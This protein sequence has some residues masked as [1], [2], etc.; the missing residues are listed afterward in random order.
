MIENCVAPLFVPA[1]R[2]ELLAKAAS[3]G[4]DAIIVDLEDAVAPA[5]KS[6][7][8]HALSG[9]LPMDVIVRIN[10]IRSPWFA[11]DAAA[12]ASPGIA[13][14]MLP[15]TETPDDIATLRAVLARPMPIIALVETPR[16]VANLDEIAPAAAR[17][18]FGTLDY[19][20]DLGCGVDSETL[21]FARSR[22]VLA[23]RLAGKP[24][25]I[26]GVT[27]DYRDITAC[28][29]DTRHAA[30]LGFGG[31]LC[32]HP[33]QVHTV[34]RGFTPSQEELRWAQRVL[35]TA[36]GAQGLDGMMVDAPVRVRAHRLLARISVTR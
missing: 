14:V 26:D 3:S 5:A 21:L 32:I 35:D 18:A 24:A 9:S 8:R 22:F 16:G 4:A 10:D 19:G 12:L 11:D 20:A 34:M 13:G 6:D 1:N 7:A 31:K 29:T 25:P 15:K 23:A 17:L 2:I 30:K 27:P 36:E 28:E 33:N